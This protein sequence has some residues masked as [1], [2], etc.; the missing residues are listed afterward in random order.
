MYPSA[1]VFDFQPSWLFT[2][3][4]SAPESASI[5]VEERLKQCPV[6]FFGSDK[7]KNVAMFFGLL[8]NILMPPGSIVQ[9]P[10]IQ[11]KIFHGW[12]AEDVMPNIS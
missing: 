10:C 7:F 9:K 8:P 12:Y 5:E 11:Q 3:T 6:Y 1:T 2:V 4:R